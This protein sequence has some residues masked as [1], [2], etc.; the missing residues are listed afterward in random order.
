MFLFGLSSLLLFTIVIGKKKPVFRF[1]HIIIYLLFF[2]VVGEGVF[3][4]RQYTRGGNLFILLCLI[5]ALFADLFLKSDKP[6]IL[7]P[8]QE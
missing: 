6:V 2:Q 3:Y 4:F 8:N 5:G 7:Y 1:N